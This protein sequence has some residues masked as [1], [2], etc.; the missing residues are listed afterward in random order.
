MFRI[1]FHR[2]RLSLDEEKAVIRTLRSG[3]LT[4]GKESIAFEEEFSQYIGD[5]VFAASVSSCTAALFLTLLALDIPKGSDILIPAL[6]YVSDVLSILHSGHHPVLMDISPS[7]Y[8]VSL[9]HIRSSITTK[10]KVVIIVHYAG[11]PCEVGSIAKFCESKGLILIE[12]CA[13]AV[14]T[15]CYGKSAGSF[16]YASVFSFYPNKNITSGEGGMIVSKDKKFIEKCKKLRNHGI[17]IDSV[18]Q[19]DAFTL[20]NFD[21]LYPGYKMNMSDIHAALGRSQL[22]SISAMHSRR[23]EIF[24][25]YKNKLSK[26]A[27][28]II[29]NEINWGENAHHLLPIEVPSENRDKL[30]RALIRNGIQPSMHFKPVHKFAFAANYHWAKVDLP[31]TENAY[32]CQISLPLYPILERAEVEYICEI[33]NESLDGEPFVT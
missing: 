24:N 14:E 31:V 8:N 21:I 12:D 13:H 16:G 7:D 6:T 10:T 4:S 26:N 18:S 22:N 20:R 33:V 9:D 3:W 23:K 2:Y 1:P 27:R 32:K 28:I 30:V 25:I 15:K 19:S 29:G 5:D 11:N 17:D